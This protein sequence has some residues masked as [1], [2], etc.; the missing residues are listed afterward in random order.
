MPGLAWHLL[1]SSS[2][3]SRRAASRSSRLRMSQRKSNLIVVRSWAIPQRSPWRRTA[4][5]LAR[6][7]QVAR[8][9]AVVSACNKAMAQGLV[10]KLWRLKSPCLRQTREFQLL[11]SKVKTP[12]RGPSS[13]WAEH[14]FLYEKVIHRTVLNV[15][16]SYDI[17]S[18]F[19]WHNTKKEGGG[20]GGVPS[21]LWL[22]F[23]PASETIASAHG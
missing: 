22:A 4:S 2:L 14:G 1:C 11:K 10:Q 3:S 9:V 7:T 8:S 16:V 20:P 15:H 12:S 18:G 17:S 23:C 5:R 6:I 21:F 13:A 19:T